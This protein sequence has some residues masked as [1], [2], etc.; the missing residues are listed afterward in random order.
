MLNRRHSQVVVIGGGIIGL[1]CAYY[2][3]RAGRKVCLIEKATVGGDEGASFGNCGLL[4]FSDLPPLCQ[5][6]AVADAMIRMTRRSSPLYIK[7]QPDPP[8]LMWLLK[9]AAKC[10]HRHFSHALAARHALF[11]RSRQ[12]YTALFARESID[13]Q[14]EQKGVLLVFKDPVRLERYRKINTALQPFGVAAARLSKSRLLEKEP[15]LSED[16]C[17]AWY[18]PMD[19]H[20]RPEALLS[21]LRA[22]LIGQGVTIVEHSPVTRLVASGGTISEAVTPKARFGADHFVL[23]AGTWSPAIA[24]QVG[25]RLPVQPGKGYSLTM[26]RPKTALHIPCYFW[27][28]SVVATPWHDGCRLGGTMEFSGLNTD[29]DRRRIDNLKSAAAAYLRDPM[30]RPTMTQWVGVRP[31]CYDD[32]P[33]IG[34]G[35]KNA[36]LFIA[37]GHGMIGLTAATATAELVTDLITGK[38]TAIDPRPYRPTRFTL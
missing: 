1:A 9:F 27:E 32:L 18:H 2:L 29:L 21:E 16:V 11:S 4:F 33:I 28:R 3:N 13:C 25:L 26:S 24:R 23:A 14:W 38:Q 15:A 5:P 6:G 20:L 37:T 17:G 36:N 34:A 8:K 12:L 35:P 30:G 31:M 10:N 7:P 19:G 22:L